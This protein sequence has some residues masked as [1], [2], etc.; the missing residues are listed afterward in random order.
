MWKFD[1][2]S[3]KRGARRNAQQDIIVPLCLIIWA[4]IPILSGYSDSAGWMKLPEIEVL[5]TAGVV[6]FLLSVFLLTFGPIS[7]GRY[8][9]EFVTVLDDHRLVTKGL[10]AVIRHPQ[11]L[12]AILWGFSIALVF[13]SMVGLILAALCFILF[14][15]RIFAEE[16]LLSEAFGREWDEYAKK[17]KRLVPFVF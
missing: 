13:Q 11:Y 6:L 9:S 3:K 1:I 2:N 10:Y 4:F 16:R 8:Y 17:V 14:L 5:R 12:G 7:L 15:W